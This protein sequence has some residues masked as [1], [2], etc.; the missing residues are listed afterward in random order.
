MRRLEAFIRVTISAFVVV[1]V[2]AVAA[3]GAESARVFII[4]DLKGNM[5]DDHPAL[6]V[7][8]ESE[9]GSWSAR[10]ELGIDSPL[11]A[12][13]LTGRLWTFR[14]KG[15]D[16][17][18]PERTVFVGSQTKE[19]VLPIWPAGTVNGRLLW[20][21]DE[22]LERLDL[23]LWP[24]SEHQGGSAA[25]GHIE[26]N[27]EGAD[28]ECALPQGKWDLKLRVPSHVSFLYWARTVGNQPVKLGTLRLVQGASVLGWVESIEGPISDA[29][30][31]L[32][33]TPFSQNL[34]ES[35]ASRLTRTSARATP[36]ERGF[37]QFDGVAPGRYVVTAMKEGYAP[38]TVF[39]VDVLE[40]A[41]TT[42]PGKV[43]LHPPVRIEVE[44]IPPLDP[45]EQAWELSLY[46]WG[47]MGTFQ[48]RRRPLVSER[49]SEA[50]TWE[51]GPL[52][53]GEYFLLLSTSWGSSWDSREI[54]LAT[55]D[56]LV[57]FLT[58]IVPVRGTVILGDVPIAARI[59][60]IRD[61]DE[62]SGAG[63]STVNAQTNFDGEFEC[64]LPGEGVWT[65]HVA[66]KQPLVQRMVPEV[67]VSRVGGSQIA[68][69]DIELADFRIRGRVVDGAGDGVPY[70]VVVLR[71]L[72]P[73]Q[74]ALGAETD[75][76]GRFEVH[77][78]AEGRY[79]GYAREGDR[80]SDNV[81]F[82]VRKD[83]SPHDLVLKL[84]EDATVRGRVVG[85]VGTGVPGASVAWMTAAASSHAPAT[86]GLDGAFETRIPRG[87]I[88]VLLYV[89]AP[90]YAL[91]VERWNGQREG[92]VLK[93]SQ[94]GGT[95]ILGG[96]GDVTA[97]GRFPALFRNGLIIPWLKGW[98]GLHGSPQPSDSEATWSIPML[99][100]GIYSACGVTLADL[101][102]AIE[103]GATGFVSDCDTGTLSP[104][105]IL[106]L[107]LE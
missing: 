81:E 11:V 14:V 99:E 40:D 4:F 77:G 17:W 43:A 36:D 89:L 93:V 68:H 44:V 38:A 3:A 75:D 20:L 70:A 84:K 21:E 12:T 8:A 31:L 74:G 29:A 51:S 69:V 26:C 107:E 24:A 28:F 18:A 1:A 103:A 91:H 32:E 56:K 85:G 73:H 25:F 49:A 9:D 71:D 65:V 64:D 19:L 97:S 100:P 50:G 96:V 78:L 54:S 79:S 33:L 82:E 101:P 16:I 30:C 41:E 98:A 23:W 72:G 6:E 86:T 76:Q 62:E 39:P 87:K 46:E 92:F 22:A 106:E 47:R 80:Q 37:F 83:R 27:L 53:P 58:D 105:N 48:T 7:T 5:P 104:G 15:R 2:A 34:E 94:L 90:G 59:S 45:L 66:S 52:S 61:A 88:T 67:R 102:A 57:H 42:I 13:V 55:S 35:D 63:G 60:F 10:T 95:V